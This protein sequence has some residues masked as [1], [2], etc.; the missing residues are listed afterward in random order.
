MTITDV[1]AATTHRAESFKNNAVANAT[2][3]EPPSR[4]RSSSEK[5]G[6]PVD[7]VEISDKA[8]TALADARKSEDLAFARKALDS[9]PSLSEE[10]VSELTERINSGYYKQADVLGQVAERAGSELKNGA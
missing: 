6:I 8:R 9:I 3:P 7:R 4:V 5:E 1:N 2:P 10:R